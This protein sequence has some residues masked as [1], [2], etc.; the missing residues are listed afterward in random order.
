M[1]RD[2]EYTVKE[3]E[4]GWNRYLNYCVSYTIEQATQK[5]DVVNVSRP[6]VPTIGGFCNSMQITEDTLLNYESK[7]GY[8]EY[9]GTIKKIKYFVK[10]FKL[11]S[12]VNG[13]GNVTGLI[14]DLKVNYGMNEKTIIDANVT[15]LT[16]QTIPVSTPLASNEKEIKE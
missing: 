15:N 2:K 7:E 1:P 11:D 3:V 9:F 10:C 16:I 4:E 13:E 5:G 12:L 14:F 6:R 8:E